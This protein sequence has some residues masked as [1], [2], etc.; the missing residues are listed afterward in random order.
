MK[1]AVPGDPKQLAPSAKDA[2]GKAQRLLDQTIPV[3]GAGDATEAQ[4]LPKGKL[5]EKQPGDDGERDVA[6]MDQL[7]MQFGVAQEATQEP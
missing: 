7:R 2:L 6:A 3:H 5:A 1:R 4:D